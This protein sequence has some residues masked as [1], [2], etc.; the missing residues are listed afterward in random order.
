MKK[1]MI[2]GILACACLSFP[3]MA[4][5]TTAP[6]SADLVLLSRQPSPGTSP[7]GSATRGG[8]SVSTMFNTAGVGY[9]AGGGG[10][11]TQ[12]TSRTTG[13]TL[14]A[15]SGAITL[16]S[17]AGSTTPASFTVTDSK[18][19]ATDVIVLNQKSGTDLYSLSVTAVA[20][21]SFQVTFNTKSGTTTEQPV[22]N[23][24]VIKG[25]AS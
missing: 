11:V 1:L 19:A 13:V 20:A 14:N 10:A 5:N 8:I 12:I 23:F 3:V 22:L 21:G 24:A 7:T 18:V 6:T 15:N 25:A 9:S 2:A 4:Q 17:A 16:V